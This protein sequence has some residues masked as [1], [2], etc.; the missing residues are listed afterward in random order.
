M[1]SHKILLYIDR[2]D[3]K[4]YNKRMYKKTFFINI[5]SLIF[6]QFLFS[7]NTITITFPHGDQK[8]FY[9][10]YLGYRNIFFED[11]RINEDDVNNFDLKIIMNIETIKMFI[12]IEQLTIHITEEN[13]YNSNIQKQSMMN[14]IIKNISILMKMG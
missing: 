12:E 10:K 9:K 5:L 13:I 1:L 14:L 2:N 8:N 3:D 4:E 6:C 11:T 7:Q